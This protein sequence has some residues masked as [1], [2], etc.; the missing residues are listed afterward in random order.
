MV[1]LIIH[2]LCNYYWE[3]P[4]ITQAKT[5]QSASNGHCFIRGHYSAHLS[6]LQII[7]HE[8]TP[9]DKRVHA[10]KAWH[11]LQS[12]SH[13]G[14]ER[15]R[16][17][18]YIYILNMRHPPRGICH[19]RTKNKELVPWFLPLGRSIPN[20]E[21]DVIRQKKI[22]RTLKINFKT[23]HFLCLHFHIIRIKLHLMN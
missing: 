12:F 15:L 9:H 21:H 18:M 1:T 5:T 2:Y 3:L 14:R 23:N 19:C 4:T 7:T 22:H 10:G 17:K 8:K 20:L 11:R 13:W 16:W 6:D